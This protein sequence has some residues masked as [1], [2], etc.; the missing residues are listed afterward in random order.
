VFEDI[1]YLM[2]QILFGHR[3][4]RPGERKRETLSRGLTD[5]G[6]QMG[7]RR[8][9]CPNDGRIIGLTRRGGARE[10]IAELTGDDRFAVHGS[11]RLACLASHG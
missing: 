10:A 6:G 5:G 2:L 9:Q 7:S 1:H 3:L 4:S 8:E 11:A